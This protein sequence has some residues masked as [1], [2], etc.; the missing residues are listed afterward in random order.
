MGVLVVGREPDLGALS[1]GYELATASSLELTI[2]LTAYDHGL[3]GLVAEAGFDADALAHASAMDRRSRARE[4]MKSI[5]SDFGVLFL[6]AT[7]PFLIG[8]ATEA[9]RHRCRTLV[10][11]YRPLRFFPPRVF[12]KRTGIQVI[13][14][15]RR[16][17]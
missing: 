13:Q 3:R 14:A 17:D 2:V 11:P 10:V 1:L 7:R 9:A 5:D 12:A 6:Q 15:Q 16:D 8:A 4:A